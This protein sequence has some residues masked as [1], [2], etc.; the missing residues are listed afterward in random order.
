[1][2]RAVRALYGTIT[3]TCLMTASQW[4]YRPTAW[5]TCGALLGLPWRRTRSGPDATRVHI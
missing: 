2:L 3:A 4:P 1:M 5:C